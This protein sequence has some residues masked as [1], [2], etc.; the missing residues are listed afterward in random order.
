MFRVIS[1]IFL[2][3]INSTSGSRT[4]LFSASHLEG[5]G[6]RAW[7]SDRNLTS[8]PCSTTQSG[9]TK[10]NP[11]SCGLFCSCNQH[12]CASRSLD[13]ASFFLTDGL[14]PS[15]HVPFWYSP[16]HVRWRRR[17]REAALASA[18]SSACTA[19]PRTFERCI[20]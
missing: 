2:P 13:Q 18:S 14:H 9:P 10:D 11:K 17:Y 16:N 12:K 6:A 5:L 4:V 1:N 8:L 15:V 3:N 7:Y 20:R 19:E